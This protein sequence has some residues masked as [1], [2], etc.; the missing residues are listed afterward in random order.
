MLYR[1]YDIGQLAEIAMK[2][3]DFNIA[4]GLSFANAAVG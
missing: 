2:G 4:A 1:R 3:V